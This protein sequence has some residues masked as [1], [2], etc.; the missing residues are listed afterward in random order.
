MGIGEI[1]KTDKGYEK[2]VGI[3]YGNPITEPVPVD[4]L[5]RTDAA[6]KQ[7]RKFAGPALNN[8]VTIE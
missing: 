8:N 6:K 4:S 5:E 3:E 2:V 1:I 7:I